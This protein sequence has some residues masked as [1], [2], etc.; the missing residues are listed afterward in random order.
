M[1]LNFRGFIIVIGL[2]L[3]NVQYRLLLYVKYIFIWPAPGGLR[4][5]H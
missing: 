3:S 2:N 5:E 4:Y 1:K